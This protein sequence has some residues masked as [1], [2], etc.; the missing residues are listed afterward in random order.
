M[1]FRNLVTSGI[2]IANKLTADLQDTVELYRWIGTNDTSAPRFEDTAITLSALV[3]YKPR[4]KQLGDGR[5]VE[6]RATVT[7]IGPIDPMP[8]WR[9]TAQADEQR[10][11]PID[12]RDKLVLSDGT[13]GPI[14][15]IKGLSDPVLAAP[16]MYEIV[17]G[18]T[19]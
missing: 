5:V 16:F 8:E 9:K 18:Y 11:E 2:G 3:E 7:V 15:D 4:L 6:A 12:S 1:G 10:H 17:L 14:L 13:T 19:Q